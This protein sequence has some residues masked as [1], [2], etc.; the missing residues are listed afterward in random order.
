MAPVISVKA[1]TARAFNPHLCAASGAMERVL[2]EVLKQL[3]G[4]EHFH[5][6][7]KR[8]RRPADQKTFKLTVEAIICDLAIRYLEVT[9]GSVH[10]SLSHRVLRRKSRYKGVALGKTLP[11][12]LKIMAAEEM[13]FIE[14]EKGMTGERL[15]GEDL[16][17]T[18]TQ[19]RQTTIKAGEKLLSRLL[20]YGITYE[21]IG[22]DPNE[23]VVLLRAKKRRNDDPA[24]S[25][26]Y[27]DTEA[28]MTMRAE[29]AAINAHLRAADIICDTSSVNSCQRRLRRIFHDGD[30]ECGG[31][32]YG[33]FWQSMKS[34]DRLFDISIDGDGVIEL[35]VGQAA[36]LILYGTIGETTP[37][38]DL[39]DLS[40]AGIPIECRDGIKKI[41]NAMISASKPLTRMPKG[42]RK[43]IPT[44]F[45]LKDVQRAID[46]AHPKLSHLWHRGIFGKVWRIESDIMVRILMMLNAEGVTALPIHDAILVADEHKELA[47]E[48]MRATYEAALGVTPKVSGKDA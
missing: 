45:S 21:D 6:L 38:G 31:R 18:Y 4:Y 8:K 14:I 42:A 25:L 41:I 29:L 15:L 13:S 27:A 19:G 9:G 22:T 11:N 3:V 5:Q 30:F 48:V 16:E 43:S 28:T 20:A 1:N 37:E 44:K 24:R 39:Y 7:R 40:S 32:L 10:L 34:D 36:V 47:G 12:I 33:G 23:E 46:V 35:D 26:E 17:F 2:D